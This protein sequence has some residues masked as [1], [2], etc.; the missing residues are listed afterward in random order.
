[1][2]NLFD[3]S[4]FTL[5]K[6]AQVGL[7]P[8]VPNTGWLPP[9]EPP[10]L[11]NAVAIA[12]DVETFD[13]DLIV[14]GPGWSRGPRGEIVGVSIAAID[15][16]SDR[17]AWYFPTRHRNEPQY[18]LPP[19]R[20]F[21]WLKTILENN[22]PK[23]GANLLY[24]I[25][26]L[27]EEN[28]FVTGELHD[29]QFAEALLDEEA[30]VALDILAS[31]YLGEHK[32]TDLMYD[33]IRSAYK[34]PDKFLR[35]EIYRTSPRLVG[36]YAEMDA[37]LPLR[38]IE[39]QLPLIK[40]EGLDYI[41][42]LECDLIPLLVRM[43]R[44][45]VS[46]DILQ[47]EA[48]AQELG[49]DA[50]KMYAHIEQEYG[51]RL[52]CTDSRQIGLLFDHVGIKYP[53][54]KAKNPSPNIEKEWLA[55]LEHPLG[56]YIN[57][58]RHHEK[59]KSTFC[60]GYIID[61][62]V[63]GKLY[64]QFHPL[65]GDVNGTMVGRFASST[66]NLQNISKRSKLGKRVRKLFIPDK[67]HDHW[68]RY[69]F[70]QIHYRI[71]AH[72]AVGPGADELRYRYCND[73]KTDYHMDVYMKVAPLLG[74]STTDKVII[75]EKRTPIKNVNF[76]LL[77][78]QSERALSYTAGLSKEQAKAFFKAYHEGAGYVK[79]TMD[80]IA[81]EAAE[82]GYV[83]TIMGRRVRFKLWE[84]CYGYG[85]T[86]L[87]L[88]QA[89]EQWGSDIRIAF[90]YRAVNYKFQGS[91]PDIMKTAMRNCLNSGVFDY[92]GV[93]R[94]TVHDELDWSV[95]DNSP[96]TQEAFKYIGYLMESAVKMR[97]PINCEF[98]TGKNWGEAD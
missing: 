14:D 55:A 92:V 74:W 28:I 44:K 57:D 88:S 82:C 10:D 41:Y 97:I 20:V 32:A 23:V 5:R 58:L 72:Y 21:P 42:R 87:P 33:W 94:L 17:G 8:P 79:P 80:A 31:K 78:G 18:N 46:V 26:W 71:L 48:L 54:T 52:K 62:N 77:Y 22:L 47:A 96:A 35:G 2:T 13:P 45:G 49:D 63:N 93:P 68:A 30:K 37:N 65:K 11:S 9:T 69:D 12:V 75:K 73:P 59:I 6:R 3:T 70:S 67:G 53:M 60:E 81:K 43:R 1:M 38:I 39:K 36:H 29:V 84:P 56:A 90:Q 66:P 76:G 4:E 40:S 25:G 51:V 64:P 83:T 98:S 85:H 95:E 50:V 91:E 24:D 15:R 19:E 86:A 61:K 34:V 89:L 27:T 16:Q 7:L